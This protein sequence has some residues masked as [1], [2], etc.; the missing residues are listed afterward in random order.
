MRAK[1][2]LLSF[3]FFKKI[4]NCEYVQI[5]LEPFILLEPHCKYLTLDFKKSCSSIEPLWRLSFYRI[6]SIVQTGIWKQGLSSKTVCSLNYCV[7]QDEELTMTFLLELVVVCSS[8]VLFSR[9][10]ELGINHCLY[11]RS[12]QTFLEELK[13]HWFLGCI[14][15]P[16]CEKTSKTKALKNQSYGS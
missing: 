2:L 5:D 16:K 4:V 11:H 10:I 9:N 6:K 1:K 13:V 12:P 15:W 7:K 8:E 14:S 3:W